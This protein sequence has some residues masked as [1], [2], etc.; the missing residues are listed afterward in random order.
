MSTTELSPL[1]SAAALG[2]IVP[3]TIQ[4]VLPEGGFKLEKGGCL[5]EITVC[6]ETCGTLNADRSN[7]VYICHALTG[8]SHV[9][10]FSP[11]QN[12]EVDKP[13][14]WWTGMVGPACGIDTARNYVICANILGG[15]KGTTGPASLNPDTGKPYGSSFPELSLRD[16]VE[17]NHL[18]INQ[19]GFTQLAAVIG[20]SFGGMQ[21]LLWSVLYPDD[22]VRSAII[23]SAASLTTQALAFDIVARHAITQDPAWN[24]GDYY[25]ANPPGHGLAN[26]RKLAHITYLSRSAMEDKFGREKRID[27]LTREQPFHERARRDFRS[28][29]EIESYLDYQGKKFV[30]RFDANSYLQIT[31]ALDDFNLGDLYGSLE[32]AIDHV[33]A[34][35]LIVSLSGDWLFTREQSRALAQA[36]LTQQK[37]VSYCHLRAPAGHDAFLT[38]IDE[39]KLIVKGFLTATPVEDPSTLDAEQAVLYRTF[40]D[41]IPQGARVLDLGCGDG[42]LLKS[43]AVQKQASCT[44]IEINLEGVVK[45]LHAGLNVIMDDLN[46]GVPIIPV[47]SFD[48]AIISHTIQVLKHPDTIIRHLLM[49][50]DKALVA[51]PNFAYWAVRFFLLLCGKMPKAKALP[52]EWYNTPNIHLCTVKDFWNFCSTYQIDAKL[53]AKTSTSKIGKL[54][55]ALGLTNLGADR[56]VFELASTDTQ[57][58]SQKAD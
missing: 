54:L 27:W 46:A 35:T 44:G 42:T 50:A 9:A 21:A 15:C 29:Y 5:K 49:I 19:L 40:A 38:H 53:I 56:V 58:R 36:Y 33:K 24:Y 34:K 11:D 4:L 16:I 18:L 31:R 28:Y 26:A 2:V 17:V 10:G 52:Y 8:D 55:I 48:V 32:A 14:G 51:F 43:V 30:K 7:A 3:Q 45:S 47:G 57:N 23:A 39:L 41:H 6:Y 12:P 1:Q 37:D 22:M 13:N 20:G 25:D